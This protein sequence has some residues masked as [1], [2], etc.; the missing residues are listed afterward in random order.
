MSAMTNSAVSSATESVVSSPTQIPPIVYFL[1]LSIKALSGLLSFTL[2]ATRT[3]IQI[4][5]YLLVPIYAASSPLQYLLSPLFVVCGVLLDALVFAPFRLVVYLAHQLYPAYVLVGTACI[6]A[7]IVGYSARFVSMVAVAAVMEPSTSPGEEVEKP[8]Q[9]LAQ[10]KTL[11]RVS[12]KEEE[13]SG[14]LRS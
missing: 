1:Q 4:L 12:I 3:S 10:K 8:T 11:K 5:Q 6:T 14:R 13:R 7:A 9:R 2:V